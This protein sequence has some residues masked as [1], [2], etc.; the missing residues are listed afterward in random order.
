MIGKKRKNAYKRRFT[1]NGD[2]NGIYRLT[3]LP[4]AEPYGFNFLV[5][6]V[7]IKVPHKWSSFI[8]EALCAIHELKKDLD[9]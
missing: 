4:L 5:G 6:N 1:L 2:P 9:L 3:A 8:G 7:P